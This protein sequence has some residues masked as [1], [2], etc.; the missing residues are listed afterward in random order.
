MAEL[1]RRPPGGQ[2]IRD[3]RLTEKGRSQ[4]LG[5]A[6]SSAPDSTPQETEFEN[7]SSNFCRATPSVALAE[8]AWAMT[9]AT[10]RRFLPHGW[11]WEVDDGKAAATRAPSLAG[12]A[13]NSVAIAPEGS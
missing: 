4:R 7:A 11:L 12:Q 5:N 2:H 9:F 3:G 8:S 13:A 6:E 10:V 1:A